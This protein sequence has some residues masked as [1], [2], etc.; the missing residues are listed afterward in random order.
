MFRPNPSPILHRGCILIYAMG[1]CTIGSAPQTCIQAGGPPSLFN[2]WHPG[3]PIIKGCPSPSSS[4]PSSSSSPSFVYLFYSLFLANFLFCPSSMAC[5]G[6]DAS[7]WGRSCRRPAPAS[8][9][10]PFPLGG[11]RLSL[12]RLPLPELHRP[13]LGAGGFLLSTHF[14]IHLRSA[15][16]EWGKTQK[17]E[18]A[19]PKK[20]VKNRIF[21]DF[22]NRT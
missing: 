4:P 1:F 15:G 9:P 22:E 2:H 5:I 11:L 18:T 13:L 14:R 10:L 3:D 6:E 17:N 16:P 8:A 21:F 20:C 7:G 12:L 19:K